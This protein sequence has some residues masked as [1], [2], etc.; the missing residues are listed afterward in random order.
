MEHDHSQHHREDR[1]GPP[2]GDSRDRKTK[3]AWIGFAVVAGFFL[4]TEHRAHLFGVLPFLLLL[5]C[6]LIHLFHHGGH[7]SGHGGHGD[8]KQ[9]KS[10]GDRT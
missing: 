1:N 7:G 9:A 10:N 8:D 3:W 5:A 2:T 4:L 6:P